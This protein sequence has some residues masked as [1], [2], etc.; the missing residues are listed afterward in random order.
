M[1]HLN[2]FG[3]FFL[4]SLYKLFGTRLAS[5]QGENF[6]VNLRLILLCSIEYVSCVNSNR[7]WLQS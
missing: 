4:S 2:T 3:L 7:T 1:Y 5:H 6:L